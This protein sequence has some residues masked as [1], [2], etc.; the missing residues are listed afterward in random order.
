MGYDIA[1][2][3]KKS[4]ICFW[5]LGTFSFCFAVFMF[6]YVYAGPHLKPTYFAVDNEQRVYLSFNSGVYAAEGDHFYPVLTGTTQSPAI[7]ITDD[8]VLYI[9]DTGDCT[10]IDLKNSVL[11]EGIIVKQTVLADQTGD[12]FDQK[13]PG[14]YRTDGQGGVEYRYSR[15]LFE[16]EIVR[17]S[18]NGEQLLFRIPRTEYVLNMIVEIGFALLMLSVAVIVVTIYRYAT[19]HPETITRF[20]LTK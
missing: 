9:A 12:L 3:P 15:T 14:G 13:S 20:S 7:T 2:I 17:E 5:I 6:S 18:E 16:Y 10:A 19:K 4:Q 1:K 8:D 11:E